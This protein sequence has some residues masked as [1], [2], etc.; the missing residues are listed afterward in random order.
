MI[1][2]VGIYIFI[3]LIL[4]CDVF[5]MIK[6]VGHYKQFDC[7]DYS[8]VPNLIEHDAQLTDI[9]AKQLLFEQEVANAQH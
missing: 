5:C 9:V 4:F 3:F 6:W 1:K 7:T 2:E 8:Q